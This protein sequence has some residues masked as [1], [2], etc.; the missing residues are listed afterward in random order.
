MRD[1]GELA[2]RQS[3]LA[4]ICDDRKSVDRR[5]QIGVR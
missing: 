4:K 3:H 1:E 2:A 5:E